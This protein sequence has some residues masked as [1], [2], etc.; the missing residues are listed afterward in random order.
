[1]KKKK[2]KKKKKS[3]QLRGVWIWWEHI[4]SGSVC[5]N[6]LNQDWKECYTL[7][8]MMTTLLPFLLRTPNGSDPLNHEAGIMCEKCPDQYTSVVK[9]MLSKHALSHQLEPF[10]KGTYNWR[11]KRLYSTTIQP[12]QCPSIRTSSSP[13][14]VSQ[15]HH[16]DLN[17]LTPTTTTT[18]TTT[19]TAFS[20]SFSSS[21]KIA[22]TNKMDNDGDS[23][24][25]D[26]NALLD[27]SDS[28]REENKNKRDKLKM[29]ATTVPMQTACNDNAMEETMKLIGR[30]GEG[31]GET[32]K[33]K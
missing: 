3:Q 1:K 22:S 11:T 6:A 33:D 10:C 4:G 9:E 15:L 8:Q 2:K 20:S 32:R 17:R 23:D 26:D 16:L 18:T 29:D 19:T 14:L 27:S 13:S 25:I 28:D 24:G 7:C 12:P 31:R 5:F 21:E 30:E